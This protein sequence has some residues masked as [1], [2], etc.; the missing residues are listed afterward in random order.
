MEL[1]CAGTPCVN[2]ELYTCT[3]KG[4]I[5]LLLAVKSGWELYAVY[6]NS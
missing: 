5:I 3:V 2:L 4:V 1:F 6:H